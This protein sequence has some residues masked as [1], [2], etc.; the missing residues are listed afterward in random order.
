MSTQY[1][2]QYYKQVVNDYIRLMSAGDWQSVA[3]L[4]ADDATVEDPVGSEPVR[5][6]EAVAAFYKRN[7]TNPMKLELAGPI[8]VAGIETAFPFTVGLNYKGAPM[9][10]HVIDL[11]KFNAEG[12]IVS[13]RAFFGEDNFVPA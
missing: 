5:G 9:Q 3:K 12:K 6:I 11:F 8:R 4:Y 1:D 13:M 2:S 10:I 7:T